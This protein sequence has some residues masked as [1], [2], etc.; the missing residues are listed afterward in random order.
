MTK[1][2]PTTTRRDLLRCTAAVPLLPLSSTDRDSDDTNP[3]SAADLLL[4]ASD[5][6]WD[7]D[8]V[9]CQIDPTESPA[10]ETLRERIPRLADADVAGTH[11]ATTD[12]WG[13]ASR[14]PDV[15]NLVIVM[16]GPAPAA[17]SVDAIVRRWLT[18][19][20]EPDIPHRFD[21]QLFVRHSRWATR[22]VCRLSI[23]DAT[24]QDVYAHQE[25]GDTLFLTNVRAYEC[26]YSAVETARQIDQTLRSRRYEWARSTPTL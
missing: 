12:R 14:P 26:Q 8:P 4:Q 2:T 11:Y 17:E 5:L 6:P 18:E 1:A 13:A 24:L 22:W 3:P 21:P 19:V 7:F 15:E 23:Q 10:F 20:Y 9:E 25:V 16:D